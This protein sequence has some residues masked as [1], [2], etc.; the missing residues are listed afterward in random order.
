MGRLACWLK[1]SSGWCWAVPG[2]EYLLNTSNSIDGQ[3]LGNKVRNAHLAQTLSVDNQV[4]A[5]KVRALCSTE[6]ENFQFLFRVTSKFP[7]GVTT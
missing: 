6:Y 2:L 5:E 7:N 1:D 4:T 3:R